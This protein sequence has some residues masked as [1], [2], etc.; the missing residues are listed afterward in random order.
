MIALDDVVIL[1]L[2]SIWMFTGRVVHVHIIIII[3]FSLTLTGRLTGGLP[4]LSQKSYGLSLP[5][6]A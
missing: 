3:F 5:I 6:E 1:W 2:S 4:L